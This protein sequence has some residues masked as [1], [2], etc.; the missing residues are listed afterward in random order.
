MVNGLA[1]NSRMNP[2]AARC[3]ELAL[4][5]FPQV[6]QI[7]T[8]APF[9]DHSTGRCCDYMITIDGMPRADQ[10]QLGDAIA[11]WHKTNAEAMRVSGVIWNRRVMGFP[12]EGDHGAYRGPYGGWRTYTGPKPHTDHVHVEYD[13]QAPTY[14]PETYP[15]G[16]TVYLD[17]LKPGTADSNSVWQLQDRLTKLGFPVPLTAAYDTDT[18][19]A[20][21]AYQQ[22]IADGKITP[23]QA[24]LLF[25]GTDITIEDK[26]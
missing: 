4:A 21:K 20:V 22:S 24:R 8:Y 3:I 7:W 17:R 5:E 16:N 15:Q 9:P 2:N 19:L 25:K 23:D 14:G 1:I 18:G 13:G 26:A 10:V 11:A 6:V 12:H